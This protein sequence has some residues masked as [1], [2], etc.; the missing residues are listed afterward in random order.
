MTSN[1]P[2]VQLLGEQLLQHSTDESAGTNNYIATSRLHGKIIGLYFS[3]HWCPPSRSFTP[4]LVEAF[5]SIYNNVKDKFDIVFLS[6]D[7]DQN[8]FDHYYQEMPWKALPFSDRTRER[9]LREKFNVTGIPCLIVLSSTCEILT[10]E[11][12]AEVNTNGADAIRRW[13]QG[14]TPRSEIV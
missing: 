2:L 1:I 9:T 3:G 12:V 5:K 6:W 4:K 8:A 11:G 7:R 10:S 14:K 13:S